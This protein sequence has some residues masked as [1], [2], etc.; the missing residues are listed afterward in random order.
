MIN[1][2]NASVYYISIG[3][4]HM[5]LFNQKVVDDE[6]LRPKSAFRVQIRYSAHKTY[7]SHSLT[8]KQF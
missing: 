1:S 2:Q 4:K 5:I 7:L 3:L 8:I 6:R